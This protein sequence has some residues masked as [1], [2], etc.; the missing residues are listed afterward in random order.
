M[1]NLKK[2]QFIEPLSP[3][4]GY[5]LLALTQKRK[6]FWVILVVVVLLILPLKDTLTT[7]TFEFR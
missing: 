2:L 4:K 7:M 6:K 5:L 3:M 1:S